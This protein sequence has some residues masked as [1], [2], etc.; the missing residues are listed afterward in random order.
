V[1]PHSAGAAGDP[2]GQCRMC[3]GARGPGPR[4]RG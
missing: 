1:R 3:G 2:S 4:A